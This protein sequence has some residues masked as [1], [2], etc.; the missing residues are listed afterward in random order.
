MTTRAALSHIHNTL[1]AMSARPGMYGTTSE[2][3]LVT[4]LA[5]LDV[6]ATLLG[7]DDSRASYEAAKA[8][9]RIPSAHH[10]CQAIDLLEIGA[11][12]ADVYVRERQRLPDAP[13]T[14]ERLLALRVD[15]RDEQA[16]AEITPEQAGRYLMARGWTR[17]DVDPWAMYSRG[18]YTLMVPLKAT[19]IDYGRRMV[20]CINGAALAEGRSPLAVWAEM[21]GAS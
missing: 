2:T 9:R 7:G 8:A 1:T 13:T 10:A 18:E 15:F 21:R 16:A 19:W 20:E 11:F 5:L 14:E 17:G 6:R 3:V 4:A 12:I